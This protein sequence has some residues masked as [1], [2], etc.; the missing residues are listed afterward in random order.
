MSDPVYDAAVDEL[1]AL[2][3]LVGQIVRG[4]ELTDEARNIWGVRLTGELLDLL[5]ARYP[6]ATGS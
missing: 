6:K 4:A 1:N 3:D 5:R 2:I